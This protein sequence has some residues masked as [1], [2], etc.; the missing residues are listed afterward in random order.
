MH[1]IIFQYKNFVISGYGVML[2]LAFY[3]GLFVAKRVSKTSGVGAHQIESL[4]FWLIVTGVLGSR[5]LY[6]FIEHPDE[7]LKNPLEFFAFQKG[8]LSF[9]GGLIFAIAFAFFW[10]KK[11]GHTFLKIADIYSPS[12]ALGLSIAKI[13]CFLVGCCH[14]RVCEVPWGIAFHSPDSHARPLGVPL[15]PTQLYESLACLVLFIILYKVAKKQPF[16]GK[17]FAL[18]MTLYGVIRFILEYFRGSESAY[19]WGLTTAQTVCIPL[20]IVGVVL[21]GFQKKKA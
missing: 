20:F 17:V 19:F 9:M 13:G 1:P 5:F 12:V 16:E 14:G 2:A 8:G 18:F 7:Y 4:A 6:T 10:C 11:H 3:V 15:H 21:Y